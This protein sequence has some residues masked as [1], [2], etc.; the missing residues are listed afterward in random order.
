M[1]PHGMNKLFAGLRIS[2][3]RWPSFPLLNIV[4]EI[5]WACLSLEGSNRG[6]EPRNDCQRIIALNN[7]FSKSLMMTSGEPLLMVS[8][9]N[10]QS[11]HSKVPSEAR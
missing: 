11:N 10:I 5:E 2:K 8:Y 4:A 9:P 3:A 6:K 1:Q 7:D